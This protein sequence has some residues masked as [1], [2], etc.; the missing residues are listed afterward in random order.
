VADARLQ[1]LQALIAHQQ[2]AIQ[3]TMLGRELDVLF[4]KPGKFEGQMMGKTGYLHA[5]HVK[6]C[7]LPRGAIARVRIIE[8]VRNSLAGELVNK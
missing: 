2:K 1:E 8:S 7:D 4:E 6:N 3:D 5:V